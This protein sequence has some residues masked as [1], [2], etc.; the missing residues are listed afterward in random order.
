MD[1][2]PIPPGAPVPIDAARAAAARR[3]TERGDGGARPAPERGEARDVV[4]L[5][6]EA[7]RLAN[8]SAAAESGERAALVAELK[9][10]VDAGSYLLDPQAVAEA[11]LE[12]DDG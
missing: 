8:L 11:L 5:S 2:N 7:R 9:S 3:A 1:V 12:H 4:S 6:D 10:S